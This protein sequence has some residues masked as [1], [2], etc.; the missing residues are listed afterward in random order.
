[1]GGSDWLGDEGKAYAAEVA[2]YFTDAGHVVAGVSTRS[3]LQA[4][5][6]AQVH[7]VKGAIRWLR[8]HA[9]EYRIDPDRAVICGGRR[10]V[11]GA[12][13]RR[14]QPGEGCGCG[15]DGR[16]AG[17]PAAAHHRPSSVRP[18][19][20]LTGVVAGAGRRTAPA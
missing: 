18:G 5:F 19:S 12:A 20:R 8:A 16:S 11:P 10:P 17:R 7:D 13:A 2:P 15:D 1:M 4:E 14:G 9:A 3:S 6:P